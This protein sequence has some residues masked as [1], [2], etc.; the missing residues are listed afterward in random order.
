MAAGLALKAENQKT[1]RKNKTK[2]IKPK[3]T[4]FDRSLEAELGWELAWAGSGQTAGLGPAKRPG[5]Q[6]LAGLS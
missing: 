5:G 6:R 1:F 3:K 2:T 4:M